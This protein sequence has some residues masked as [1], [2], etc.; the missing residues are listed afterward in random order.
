M[1]KEK[2]FLYSLIYCYNLAST[3]KVAWPSGLRRW[4]K[5]PVSSG[6]W[7]RIPPLPNHDFTFFPYC[8]HGA[9]LLPDKPWI[10]LWRPN[11]LGVWFLLWV[12][13]VRGSNPRLA[14]AF[15]C[16]ERESDYVQ[17]RRGHSELNQG[18]A[19][20]QPDALP[21]SY[22]PHFVSKIPNPMSKSCKMPPQGIIFY[23]NTRLC[24]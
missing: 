13:E 11:G 15:W 17:K 12:Q 16:G 1:L 7:V 6:A 24:E 3:K 22:I 19:G 2:T 8:A 5:A 10:S 9:Y 4:F 18:P 21:L 23:S 20:L 14:H